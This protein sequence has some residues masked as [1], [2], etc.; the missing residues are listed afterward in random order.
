M[1]VS[2]TS[3]ALCFLRLTVTAGVRFALKFSFCC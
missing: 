1:E 2:G 3:P